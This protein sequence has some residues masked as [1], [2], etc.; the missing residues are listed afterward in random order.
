MIVGANAMQ[1]AVQIPSSMITALNGLLVIFVVSS[2][3]W[4]RRMVMRQQKA[5]A[6]EAWR[7]LSAG[8]GTAMIQDLLTPA[9]LAGIVYSGIRLATPYLYATLGETIGQLSGVLNLG[10]EGIM[11]MGAYAGFYLTFRT[12]N[13][14]IGLL[15]AIIVGALLGLAIAVI[16]VTLEGRAGDQRDRHASCSGWG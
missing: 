10:V 11:L 15:A 12:G 9:V 5:E 13:P 8:A 1:R 6:A 7:W 14:W 2:D 3:I 16:T 4:R